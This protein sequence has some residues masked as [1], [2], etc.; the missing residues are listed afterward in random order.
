MGYTKRTYEIVIDRSGPKPLP[1]LTENGKV[2]PKKN[3]LIFNKNTDKLKKV[4]HYRVKFKIKDFSNSSLKFIPDKD[5]VMWAQ[6]GGE[7]AC[8][9]SPCSMPTVFWVDDMDSDGEWIDVIN[10]DLVKQD[11]WFTLNLCDKSIT[12]PTQADYVPL[13]PGGGNQNMGGSGSGLLVLKA[14]LTTGGVT[15]AVVAMGTMALTNSAFVA[16][17]VALAGL[18]GAAVGLAVGFVFA[19]T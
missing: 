3:L 14:V 8:P 1:V 19:R 12:N 4:D 2:I 16:Q 15:G 10:M 7:S 6:P 11:F 5:N 13:D 18:A 9:T 17:T